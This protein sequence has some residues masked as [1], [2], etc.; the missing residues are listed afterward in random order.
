MPKTHKGHMNEAIASVK[1]Q[2]KNNIH[3]MEHYDTVR[4]NELR[5]M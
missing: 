3:A 2:I 5:S 1:E 4:L